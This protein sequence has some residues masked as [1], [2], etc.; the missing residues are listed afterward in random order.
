MPSPAAFSRCFFFNVSHIYSHAFYFSHFFQFSPFLSTILSRYWACENFTVT[1]S[2]WM[3]GT[4]PGNT[5][6]TSRLL[7]MGVT[8]GNSAVFCAFWNS[9]I[10][11]WSQS[12]RTLKLRKVFRVECCMSFSN[13]VC[14][15]PT[16]DW[17]VSWPRCHGSKD[18]IIENS[19]C[20]ACEFPLLRLCI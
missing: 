19:R 16:T 15:K 17:W 2:V 5:T 3:V 6:G 7:S 8:S 12:N 1:C 9:G 20:R 11:R 4:C 13:R 18:I 14:G 10:G